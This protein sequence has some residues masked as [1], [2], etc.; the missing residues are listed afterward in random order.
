MP[1]SE[2]G[3]VTPAMNVGHSRRRKMNITM[4]TSAMLMSRVVCTSWTDARMVCVRS[5][6]TASL[7]PGGSQRCNCGSSWRI[8]SA[9]SMTFAV[10][11]LRTNRSTAR[12]VPLQPAVWTLFCAS[13]TRAMEPNCTGTPLCCVTISER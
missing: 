9:I 11:C 5:L 12:L 1:A 3:T 10:D 13:M 8:W 4:I 6:M 2:S 7:T